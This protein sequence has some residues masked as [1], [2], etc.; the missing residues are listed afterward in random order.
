MRRFHFKP[1]DRLAGD[2]F[3]VGNSHSSGNGSQ[4]ENMDARKAVCRSSTSVVCA[5][6]PAKRATKFEYAR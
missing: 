2:D 6:S 3:H 4:V 5:L 1:G